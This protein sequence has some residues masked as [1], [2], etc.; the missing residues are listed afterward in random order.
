MAE[1]RATIEVNLERPP[2]AG[3]WGWW[4]R[5]EP[6]PGLALAAASGFGLAF[7]LRGLVPVPVLEAAGWAPL[8]ALS[9]LAL[10]P[11]VLIWLANGHWLWLVDTDLLRPL[12]ASFVV[13]LAANGLDACLP[14][15]T[16]ARQLTMAVLA[17]A[18]LPLL[19][20]LSLAV[21]RLI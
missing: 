17:C 5:F 21:G 7:P 8:V 12:G 14:T 9:G 19:G 18:A 4:S 6:W 11:E 2:T 16:P 10:V 20:G 15:S 13:F 1:R 3:G